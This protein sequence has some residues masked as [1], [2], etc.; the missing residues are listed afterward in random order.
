[1]PSFRC[2]EVSYQPEW[3]AHDVLA[4]VHVFVRDIT[5]ER[6]NERR[7][8][9]ESHTDHLTGLLNRKGFDQALAGA[10]RVAREGGGAQ[11]LLFVDL[12]RFKLVNDTWGHALGDEL[13]RR[14]AK[15][16]VAS[17]REG[18]VIARYGG[19]EFAVIMRDVQDILD[20]ERTAMSILDA[21]SRPMSLSVGAV[22]VGACVGVAMV[23]SGEVK[24]PDMMFDAADRALYDAKHGG[25]GR[26]VLGDGACVAD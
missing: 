21:A 16:L 3:A 5:V 12:D 20:V 2:F 14:L 6:S 22:T 17:V 18:D 7:W 23:A 11:A 10:L 4:G 8:R 19:D 25:R 26:F 1:M 9:R 13:L 24:T 15:R